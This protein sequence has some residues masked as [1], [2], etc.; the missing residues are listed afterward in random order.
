MSQIVYISHPKP[1]PPP[2]NMASDPRQFAL[3]LP[4]NG[5]S[6]HT[7]AAKTH[8]SYSTVRRLYSTI[9]HT[10]SRQH[11]GCPTKLSPKTER[12]LFRKTPLE[13]L[14]LPLNSRKLWIWM[15]VSRSSGIHWQRRGW[16]PQLSSK[17]L[18]FQGSWEGRAG[19]CFGAPVLDFGGLKR[20]AWSGWTK[21]NRLRPVGRL[22]ALKK[23]GIEQPIKVT[24][25][26]GGESLMVWTS[27]TPLSMCPWW[28]GYTY[29]Y[30]KFPWV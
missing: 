8:L 17:A 30:P 11:G 29:P 21:F 15:Y 13:Q 16:S 19:C 18:S 2:T 14:I 25:K 7:V 3:T 12:P 24:V 5:N 9:S 26:C 1:S 28:S 22:W 10:L 20:V 4:Q 6:C 23:Q 27:T